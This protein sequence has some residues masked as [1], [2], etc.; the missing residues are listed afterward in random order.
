ME[1][2]EACRRSIFLRFGYLGK[3]SPCSFESLTTSGKYFGTMYL[4]LYV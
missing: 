3:W 4:V 2:L 1:I